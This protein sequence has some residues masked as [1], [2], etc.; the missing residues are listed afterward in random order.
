MTA[1]LIPARLGHILLLERRV[2]DEAKALE[3]FMAPDSIRAAARLFRGSRYTRAFRIDGLVYAAY[4]VSGAMLAPK[5]MLWLMVDPAIRSHMRV[6]MRV[7]RS[8]FERLKREEPGLY[9]VVISDDEIGCRF[10]RHFGFHLGEP[11]PLGFRMAEL[12]E[13]A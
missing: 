9:S 11:L 13:A 5:A 8:E 2:R 6:F 10:A 4:G 3:R 1:D 12:K 7:L